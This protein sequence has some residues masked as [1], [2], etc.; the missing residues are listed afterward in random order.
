[1]TKLKRTYIANI[2][3]VIIMAESFIF[4]VLPLTIGFNAF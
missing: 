2:D 1:M 3:V 4:V